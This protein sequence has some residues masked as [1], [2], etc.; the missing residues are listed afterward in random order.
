VAL[1]LPLALLSPAADYIFD[2]VIAIDVALL[3]LF[4]QLVAYSFG[5][6]FRSLRVTDIAILSKT[7]DITVPVFLSFVGVYY[8]NHG[9][10]WILPAIF[11]IFLL[12]A[13]M[14]VA[15]N[16]VWAVLSLVAILSA[17]GIYSYFIGFN[18]LLKNSLWGLISFTFAILV[19]RLV[20][21]LLIT[22]SRQGIFGALNFPIEIFT[23]QGFYIRGFL[24]AITQLSFVIAISANNLLLVWPI[25][26][27]TGFMGA[28]FAYLFLGER[29]H[30]KDFIC[31]FVTFVLTGL[32]MLM[33]NYENF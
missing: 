10:I 6:A 28:F 32:A 18:L 19:W 16:S 15:K 30:I 7:A 23:L 26:N 2:D 9:V 11:L 14:R 33:L 24:T 8:V 5:Y 21:S 27:T 13:G 29:F 12:S 31:I 1:I 3:A 4:I 25:L 17:Q 22:M 20:F